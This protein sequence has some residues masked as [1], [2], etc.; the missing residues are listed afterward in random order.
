MKRIEC[1]ESGTHNGTWQCY[2]YYEAL[3]RF[4]AEVRLYV[5]S[6]VYFLV[7]ILVCLCA[8]CVYV[9]LYSLCLL[10]SGVCLSFLIDFMLCY[11]PNLCN[12]ATV[13]YLILVILPG[14][15]L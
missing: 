12:R 5:C 4:L 2:G 11:T 14:M 9:C 8:F 1:F 6:F 10:V 13:L 3:N 15:F 7:C